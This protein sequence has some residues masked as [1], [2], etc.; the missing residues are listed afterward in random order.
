MYKTVLVAGIALGLG[1]SEFSIAKNWNTSSD[2]TRYDNCK[3]RDFDGPGS[4]QTAGYLINYKTCYIGSDVYTNEGVTSSICEHG[5]DI[6]NELFLDV[7][8]AAPGEII[9]LVRDDDSEESINRGALVYLAHNGF[10]SGYHHLENIPRGLQE[11]DF[12]NRGQKIGEVGLT[13]A[14]RRPHLHFT[15]NKLRLNNTKGKFLFTHKLWA[16]SDEAIQSK[17]VEVPFFD[18][19]KSYPDDRITFPMSLEDCSDQTWDLTEHPTK[20]WRGR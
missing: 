17:R 3:Q 7:I 20:P 19:S 15:T 5:I 11:G 2:R 18:E 9:E 4:G 1:I 12:V 6:G 13:G 10:A 16:V 14:T 8:A